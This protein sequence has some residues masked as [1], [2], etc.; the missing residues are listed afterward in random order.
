MGWK[1]TRPFHDNPIIEGAKDLVPDVVREAGRAVDDAV[2]HPVGKA[3]EDAAQQSW[4][5]MSPQALVGNGLDSMGFKKAG[6]LVKGPSWEDLGKPGQAFAEDFD[7]H[8]GVLPPSWRQ[9]AAPVT[10]ALLNFIPGVGPLVSAGFTTAYNAGKM[11]QN[12]KGME[13]GKVGVDALKNFGTAAVGTAMQ[14]ANAAAK[15]AQAGNA[16]TRAGLAAS[17]IA[18]PTFAMS[19]APNAMSAFGGAAPLASTAA[20]SANT[21]AQAMKFLDQGYS[22]ALAANAAKGTNNAVAGPEALDAEAFRASDQGMGAGYSAQT[23]DTS[24]PATNT[25]KV[26]SAQPQALPMSTN[27]ANKAYNS[28][29]DSLSTTGQA[30]SQLAGVA[31]TLAAPG[32]KPATSM[33]SFDSTGSGTYDGYQFGDMLGAYGGVYAPNPEGRRIGGTQL[34]EMTQRVGV[35]NYLQT[36]NARDTFLPTGQ[37]EVQPNTPYTNQMTN[38]DTSTNKSY[39]DLLREVDNYNAY[40]GIIDANPGMTEDIANTFINNPDLQVPNQQGQN[41]W[42]GIQPMSMFNTSMIR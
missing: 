31:Q 39:Q 30:K 19:S 29:T 37:T 21:A 1:W 5:N 24:L 16:S 28:V 10:S 35:N 20:K 7:R 36:Q 14:G 4:D 32:A 25:Y 33:D 2:I 40:Y 11:Q 34:D 42:Q 17:N 41:L 22:S 15:T 38:I 18:Q 26:S 6:A 23:G 13:W 9:Y 3:I 8:A 12:Q 27:V